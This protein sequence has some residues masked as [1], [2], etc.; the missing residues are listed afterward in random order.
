[1]TAPMAPGLFTEP[2]WQ[3][4]QQLL[5]DLDRQQALWL[6]GFLAGQGSE[7]APAPVA[8]NTPVQARIL[9]AFGSE[10]GN[11]EALARQLASRA[12]EAGLVADVAN[13]AGLRLRQ[14]Q[15][16]NR[17]LLICSTHGD[18]DPPEP[19][20]AFH[21]SLMHSDAPA[22]PHLEYAVLALGDSSYEH[23]CATGRELDERLAA[24]GAKRLLPRR[25]CDVDFAVPARAWMQEALSR[26]PVAGN[27]KTSTATP[28][29]HR[30]ESAQRYGKQSPLTVEVLGNIRL[31][32]ATRRDPVHHIELALDAGDFPI[33]PGDAVGI[34]TDNPPAL[35]A[36]LL[37][38]TGLSG[39]QPVMQG[40]QAMPL[41]Q[42]LRQECNLTIP[43]KRFLEIWAEQS[44]SAEL[45]AIVADSGKQRDFLRQ[46]QVIDIVTH[47]PAHPEAQTLVDGLRPLQ[48]RLYDV[49]NSLRHV[50]DEL[51]LTIRR[52]HYPFRN[53]EETGIAS[54]YLLKLQPGDRLRLYPHRNARFHLPE[55]HHA[56]LVL[57]AEGTGIAPY[58][59]FLQD[60]LASGRSHPCWLFFAEQRFREDFLYQT[61]WQE[62]RRQNVLERITPVFSHDTPGLTLA[63]ALGNALAREAGGINDWLDR[64][65]HLYFCGDKALMEHGEHHLRSHPALAT[66]WE[67]LVRDKRLHRNLY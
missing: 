26:L 7:A 55:D 18:G 19:I 17:L 58:R 56:P 41:V 59:A 25:E 51:H 38:A 8:A 40:E 12:S 54:E 4:V 28:V 67:G 13:L 45:R 31:S 9:I 57:V 32:A 10:T 53:R 3:A 16:H 34:L 33:E 11:C 65:A 30:S 60:I 22:F 62:A 37:K 27:T 35:V 43:G 61:D 46:W 64:G 2:Q 14:L 39:E 5:R 52:Y 63:D 48:P 15:K 29:V 1:M 42:A 21:E 36:A 20:T 47:W 23:F 6:S 44:G 49:A 24:L 66:A 50:A